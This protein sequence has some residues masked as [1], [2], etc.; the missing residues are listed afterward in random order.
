MIDEPFK[1]RSVHNSYTIYL[2]VTI[3]G[4]RFKKST[5]IRC[6]PDQ[7]NQEDQVI[8]RNHPSRRDANIILNDF[9]ER[10]TYIYNNLESVRYREDI[11]QLWE[12]TEPKNN[13]PYLL[14]YIETQILEQAK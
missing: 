8:R 11:E 12:Y 10:L 14:D 9:E 4:H 13:G 6:T 1:V 3:K 5:G 7:F 2:D